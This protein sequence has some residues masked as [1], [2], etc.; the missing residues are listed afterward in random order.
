MQ[1]N[2]SYQPEEV[3]YDRGGRGKAEIN[4]VKISTPKPPRKTDSHYQKQKKRKKFRRRAAIE[5][6]I[7]HLKKEFRMEQNYLSGSKS[8]R[9]NAMLAAAGWN[10]KKL[11]EKLKKE[12]SWLYIFM[13]KI[14]DTYILISLKN[15]DLSS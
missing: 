13:R 4:E 8:P 7:G 6:L 12:I 15:Y 3:V 5:P 10:L 2:L 14:L 1:E 11:M 9:I